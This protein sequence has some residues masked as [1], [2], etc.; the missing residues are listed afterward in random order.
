MAGHSKWKQI[1][2][3]K[4]VTDKKRGAMY[5]KHLAAIT[6]AVRSGGSGDPSANDPQSGCHFNSSA[7]SGMALLDHPQIDCGGGDHPIDRTQLGA[8]QAN[9]TAASLEMSRDYQDRSPVIELVLAAAHM[10]RDMRAAAIRELEIE[11]HAVEFL[12]A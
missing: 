2:R 6:A 10:G 11:Q 4:A 3:K 8:A 5:S 12:V 1:K 7:V 9:L